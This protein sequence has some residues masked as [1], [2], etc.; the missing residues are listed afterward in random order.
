[1]ATESEAELL[2]LLSHTRGCDGTKCSTCRQIDLRL[3]DGVQHATSDPALRLSAVG[4]VLV[5]MRV[6]V[7]RI[8]LVLE[9]APVPASTRRAVHQLTEYVDAATQALRL[10]VVLSAREA[11]RAKPRPTPV[12]IG[13]EP[14]DDEDH[15]PDDE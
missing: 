7:E 12:M 15:W 3:L 9:G 5:Q 8:F 6:Q 14:D 11:K 2:R 10:P 4:S 13:P 1:M